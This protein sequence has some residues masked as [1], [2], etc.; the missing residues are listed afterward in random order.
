MRLVVADLSVTD[1]SGEE[2]LGAARERLA[3][4]YYGARNFG[5]FYLAREDRE[6][7]EEQVAANRHLAALVKELRALV[8]FG[9]RSS[10]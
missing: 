7:R 8:G 4:L 2:I 3:G 5:D 6:D 10:R 9:Q 1:A